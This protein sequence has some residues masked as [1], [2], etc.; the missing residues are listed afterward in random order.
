MGPSGGPVGP[1]GDVGPQG[2]EG[3]AGPKGDK[4]DDGV[5]NIPGPKGDTGLAGPKG[6]T[7]DA[8]PQGIQGPVGPAGAD[9]TGGGAASFADLTDTPTAD[10]STFFGKTISF[11]EDGTIIIVDRLSGPTTFVGLNDTPENYFGSAGMFVAS[12]GAGL[13]FVPAPEGG[14]AAPVTEPVKSTH[15]RVKFTGAINPNFVSIREMEF[16]NAQATGGNPIFSSQFDATTYDASK[17]FDGNKVSGAWA[18]VQGGKP[19]AYLGYVFP[20][21]KAV[22]SIQITGSDDPQQSPSG[23]IIQM[24][25][26]SGV[27]WNDV[28]TY[29]DLVW[30]VGEEKSFTVPE[31][32]VVDGPVLNPNAGY[33]YWR[34]FV[35]ANNGDTDYT[36]IK[37]AFFDADGVNVSAAI[38]AGD[39]S[40]INSQ[41]TG[42]YSHDKA[43]TPWTSD[44]TNYFSTNI[45]PMPAAVS[46]YTA[47][48]VVIDYVTIT[49]VRLAAR[50]PKDFEI[51]CSK[52]GVIWNTV[53]TVYNQTGWALANSDTR[54]YNLPD[55]PNLYLED[56][57]RQY[58]LATFVAGTFAPSEVVQYHA[59]VNNIELKNFGSISGLAK[60]ASTDTYEV[61]IQKN[62]V[63]FAVMSFE[64]S[65][66][67]SIRKFVPTT[68]NV[69]DVISI[70]GAG[71]QNPALTDIS[72]TVK[73]AIL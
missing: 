16:N 61:S 40:G 73:G 6:D 52:D 55:V 39:V 21:T 43:F 4:G 22:T 41:A 50:V 38:P 13:E 72:I 65:V 9:G 10:Y 34:L 15:W 2:P 28:I 23:I 48:P 11:A 18:T 45:G 47:T 46:F 51:Q 8:G 31:E 44:T 3:P 25:D 66:K 49:G 57:G 17:A 63:E 7:G 42:S 26:D 14:G 64:T 70:V 54:Q 20:N 35:N 37:A 19:N 36:S 62:D 27:S 60:N 12:T 58:T 53:S 71:V 32:T 59:V 24:S 29:P 67:P 69:G 30:T 5:S 56:V 1:S 68:F 33:S